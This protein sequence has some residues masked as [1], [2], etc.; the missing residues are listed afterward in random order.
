MG[1]TTRS[2]SLYPNLEIDA[3]DLVPEVFDY[4]PYYH[5]DADKVRQHPG[6]N[7]HVNDGRNHLLVTNKEYDLITVDPAPPVHAAGTVNL[8]TREFFT[9]AK[10]RLSADG[11]F[12][13]WLPPTKE[14]ELVRIMRTFVDV[15]P[16]GSIWGALEYPGFYLTGGRRPIRPTAEER[17]EIVRKLQKID[18][19]REWTNVYSDESQLQ[20]LYLMDAKELGR[21]LSDVPVVTDDRPST[22]FPLWRFLWNPT[23]WRMLVPESFRDRSSAFWREHQQSHRAAAGVAEAGSRR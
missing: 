19:L 9:L 20:S 2:A 4:F 1:T 11:V 17:T 23:G 12:C 5:A 21:L 6:L 14:S 3:V 15:F 13:L 8:Y 16:D 18:D 10:S 7:F 22:E